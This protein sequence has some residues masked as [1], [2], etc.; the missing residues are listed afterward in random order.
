MFV[1]FCFDSIRFVSFCFRCG[2][3]LFKYSIFILLTLSV[4]VVYLFIYSPYNYYC[5]WLLSFYQ[6]TT[7]TTKVCIIHYWASVVLFIYSADTLSCFLQFQIQIHAY[8]YFHWLH[9]HTEKVLLQNICNTYTSKQHKQ[10][11]L[12]IC[13]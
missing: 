9:S 2:T 12:N 10:T 3:L 1:Y 5:C 11:L 7:T 4:Y 13:I 6:T 8:I